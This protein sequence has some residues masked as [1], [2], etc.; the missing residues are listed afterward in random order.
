VFFPAIGLGTAY[1]FAITSQYGDYRVDKADPFGFA[2]EMRPRTASRVWDLS[3]FDWADEDWL[4]HRRQA[5][6]LESPMSIYEVHLGSWRRVPDEDNRWLSY[7]EL[8]PL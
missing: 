4:A 6:V 1:K 8:A 2:A 5:K 7:R 3:G